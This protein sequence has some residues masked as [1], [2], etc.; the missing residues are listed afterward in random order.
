MLEGI[1]T[2]AKY[3]NNTYTIFSDKTVT[4]KTNQNLSI[5]DK[6][7]FD[8]ITDS[9][10]ISNN[11]KVIQRLTKEE[12]NKILD[13]YISKLLRTIEFE[14]NKLNLLKN[15]KNQIP[16]NILNKIIEILTKALI[17]FLKTFI[18]GAPIIIRFHNDGDG[19]GGALSL[20]TAVKELQNNLFQNKNIFWEIQ[21]TI[22]Y[23]VESF[24]NDNLLFNNYTTVEKP[25]L[26]IIDF[27]SALKSIDQVIDINNN[28]KLIWID[29]HQ[30]DEFKIFETLTYYI[31]SWRFGGD[32]N[33]TAGLISYMF[34]S[35]ITRKNIDIF[36]EA[37]LFSDHS[38]YAIN[39]DNVTKMSLILDFL[40]GTRTYN[41][42][43][44]SEIYK[45]I[46]DEKK[47][48]EIFIH[49][50]NVIDEQLEKG[51][52]HI[53]TFHKND[54]YICSLDFET[55]KEEKNNEYILPGRYSS[56]IHDIISQ[57]HNKL[58]TIVYYGKFIS[59][60]ICKNISNSIKLLEILKELKESSEYIE[61]YGGHSEAASIK[62]KLVDKKITNNIILNL[63]KE[64]EKC[65]FD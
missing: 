24:L 13:E 62:I 21:R 27:G 56:K 63:I 22:I 64:L 39:S 2:S 57:E 20:Y 45:I 46:N 47:K 16:I 32:A 11:I 61:S 33:I 37:S 30:Y 60:R 58:I 43:S 12:F 14:Q 35:L 17:E 9:N 36:K 50:Q 18:T 26:F 8:E 5:Y 38:I 49:A 52:Q 65:N 7:T 53:K 19:I 1:V 44:L 15:L 34:S 59:I 51:L 42:L 29:H 40:T 54:L 10:L 6:I 4:I 28:Y 3:Y 55:T 48:Q 23:D 41:N 25:L 31:N